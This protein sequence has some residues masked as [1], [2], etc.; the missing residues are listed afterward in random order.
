MGFRI[1]NIKSRA[2]LECRLGYLVVRGDTEKRVAISEINTLILQS[3]AV[4]LTAS[5]LGELVE[6]NVKV[7][8]CDRKC[9]PV[10]EL[11]PYYGVHN[12]A[13]RIREQILWQDDVKDAVWREIVIKK[14]LGQAEHLD[15]LGFGREAAMLVGYSSEVT[16]GDLTNR[17]GHAAKVYFNCIFGGT[18]GRRTE[19]FENA[20]L[21]YG[22]AVLLSAFNREIAACGYL[23]QL[24]IWHHNDYNDFNL[25][26]D[27]MEPLRVI[28][29]R[30]MLTLNEED[31]DFK[32]EMAQI[33]NARAV[34]MGRHTTLDL[35]IRNYVRSVV[36]RLNGDSDPLLFPEQVRFV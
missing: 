36:C 11:M 10:S 5:L 7:I 20:C 33:L 2:K 1:I 14:I 23:T 26:C 31:S 3:T 16:P 9:N 6:N 17:E 29:D 24:G 32:R 30:K 4:S 21:N 27:L 25:A 15:E 28:V 12:S 35:A 13:R 34:S 8:F 19:S 22:Y 18:N